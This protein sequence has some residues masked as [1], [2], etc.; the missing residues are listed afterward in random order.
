M[1]FLESSFG[2][3]SPV[4]DIEYIGTV[5]FLF[6]FTHEGHHTVD[7]HVIMKEPIF[8]G[9]DDDDDDDG[10]SDIHNHE[11]MRACEIENKTI[12][13]QM[14]NRLPYEKRIDVSLLRC[15]NGKMRIG[16]S[17]LDVACLCM[18]SRRYAKTLVDNNNE[19]VNCQHLL[20]FGGKFKT[21]YVSVPQMI[22][23]VANL[24]QTKPKSQERLKH[25]E[26]LSTRSCLSRV[27]DVGIFYRSRIQRMRSELL[28]SM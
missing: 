17:L 14:Q 22:K 11:T 19:L 6:N 24:T 2:E 26:C 10:L 5:H 12:L 20:P 7:T 9:N 3:P 16:V 13:Q 25:I 23:I 4:I 15:E 27:I 8:R 1:D 21:S 28:D 18:I